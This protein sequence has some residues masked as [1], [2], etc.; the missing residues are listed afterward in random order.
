VCDCQPVDTAVL[1]VLLVLIA[2]TVPPTIVSL[3]FAGSQLRELR[4]RDK[5]LQAR[6]GDSQ[7]EGD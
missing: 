4:K 6:A 7:V 5:D 3:Y 1:V 2:V